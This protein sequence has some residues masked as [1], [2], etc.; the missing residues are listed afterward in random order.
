MFEYCDRGIWCWQKFHNFLKIVFP[1]L[2]VLILE[3]NFSPDKCM[4]N[5]KATNNCDCESNSGYEIEHF[6]QFMQTTTIDIVII[7]DLQTDFEGEII[8]GP[9]KYFI[10]IY[11]GS[12]EGYIEDPIQDNMHKLIKTTDYIKIDQLTLNN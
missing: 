7:N 5:S 1:N 2:Q 4:C 8:L 10:Q 6:N 3:Q 12:D 11:K 9:N